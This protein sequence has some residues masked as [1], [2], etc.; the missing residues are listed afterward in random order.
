MLFMN[1]LLYLILFYEINGLPQINLDLTHWTSNTESNSSLQHDCL[2]VAGWIENEES[3]PYEIISYCMS[4]W[5]SRWNIKK[6]NQ[7]QYFTFAQLYQL[8]IISE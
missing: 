1:Y 8:N 5:P 3:D 7:D 2:H 6:N 4:E